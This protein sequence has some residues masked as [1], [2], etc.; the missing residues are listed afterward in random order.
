VLYRRAL[1][2]IR[3]NPVLRAVYERL[4]A[5]GRPKKLALTAAMR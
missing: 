1:V 5:A 2:A 4:V 3:H